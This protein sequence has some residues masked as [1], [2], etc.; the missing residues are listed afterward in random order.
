MARVSGSTVA[1]AI[2]MRSWLHLR[3]L[4]TV[5]LAVSAVAVPAQAD[6][7]SSEDTRAYASEFLG[8]QWSNELLLGRFASV[9]A[10]QQGGAYLGVGTDQ[11]FTL[12]SYGNHDHAYLIDTDPRVVAVNHAYLALHKIAGTRAE[13]VGYLLGKQPA[14]ARQGETLKQ[15]V[16]RTHQRPDLPAGHLLELARQGYDRGGLSGREAG[17]LSALMGDGHSRGLYLNGL[18]V[19]VGE[20]LASVPSWAEPGDAACWLFEERLYRRVRDQIVGGRV[21]VRRGSLEGAAVMKSIASDAGRRG[22]SFSTIYIS[23]ADEYVDRNG[24]LDRLADN[25]QELPANEARVLRTYDYQRRRYRS[26]HVR[27]RS[28]WRYQAAP[29]VDYVDTL[30]QLEDGQAP[31]A[32]LVALT[33]PAELPTPTAPPGPAVRKKGRMVKKKKAKPSSAGP[34]LPKQTSRWSVDRLRRQVLER[35]GRSGAGGGGRRRFKARIGG[36]RR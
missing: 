22:L 20:R 23:N 14:A 5:M 4:P 35:V 24:T 36:T 26:G 1:A 7:G 17:A 2:A 21:T 6:R 34:T 3:A 25:L 12:L 8:H 33:Q 28:L 32:A 15:L 19:H 16:E 29:L 13:F 27:K 31:M 10:K 11:N 18:R 9:V 30:K